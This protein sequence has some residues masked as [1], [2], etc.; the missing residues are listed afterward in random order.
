MVKVNNLDKVLWSEQNVNKAGL[1]AYYGSMAHTILP[2]LKD[3]PLSIYIKHLSPTAP[4]LYIKDME[5]RQPAFAD[6]FETPRK[7]AKKGKREIIEYLVCNN[8]ATLLYVI[9]LGA[10]D[11]NPW[12][13]RTT[14]PETPDY[15]TI[16]LDPSDGDF[17]KAIEAA[18]AAKEIFSEQR[19]K[20][21]V[22]TSG[23][24]GLHL[25]I[26][27]SGFSFPE[28]RAIGSKICD[29]VQRRVPAITTR[30][31]SVDKRGNLLYVDD[32]QNDFADTIAAPYSV[33]PYRI[34]SVSTPLDWKEVKPGLDPAAFTIHTIRKR[35]DKKGDLFKG[36]FDGKV[37][38][39]NN[40]I[41]G[42]W[43]NT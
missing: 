4:G 19:L 35:L 37:V 36:L 25:L 21:F 33:R 11:L 31:R 26:P 8:A 14:S 17:N 20:T 16:D 1:L 27:C 5:G 39:T 38:E 22:K 30:E 13:S 28:A 2:Y 15:I 34:P 9:N 24:T 18:R 23:K 42:G 40:K 6:T 10:I 32:S 3:R 29:E 12:S 43:G 7:H 41:C